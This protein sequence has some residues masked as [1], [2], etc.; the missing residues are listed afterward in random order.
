MIVIIAAAVDVRAADDAEAWKFFEAKV[1]PVLVERCLKC[2]GEAQQ[3]GQLRLDS[4]EAVLKGGESGEVVVVGKPDESLLIEAINRTGLEMPPDGPLKEHEIAA[5][6]EWVRRG[7]PWPSVEGKSRTLGVGRQISDAD[8][9]YW[10]FQPIRDPD[11]PVGSAARLS[12]PNWPRNEIDEFIAARLGTEGFVP[13]PEADRRTLLRRLT[14]DLT[15]L[16]PTPAE[17]ADFEH[18]ARDDAYER[19]VDRLLDSP[20]YGERWARHWLDLV[21]YAESDGYRK[22]DYRP[23]AWRYRDYVI[24][25]FQNDKSFDQFVQEQI[26]GDEIDPEN[27]DARTAT[28]YMRLGLYEYN[29]RDVRTQWDEILNDITDVT[30]E[31]FLGFGMGCARCHDHKFD[32]ILRKDYF[33]LRAFFAGIL[34]QDDLPLATR[35][36]IDAY[37]AK[38]AEWEAATADLRAQLADVE[39]AYRAKSRA[40]AISKFPA[41]IQGLLK[42]DDPDRLAPLDR[43]L[44]DLA[45]RQVQLEYDSVGTKLKEDAKQKW[46]ELQAEL[47][48]FDSLKPAPLPTGNTVIDVGPIAPPTIIPG[49]QSATDIPPGLLSVIDPSPAHIVPPPAAPNSSGRRTQ[50]ARWLTSPTNP[51][52]PRVMVNRIWQYHFGKGLVATSSDF[53]RLGETP[54]H[55]EL[56]DWLACRFVG[57]AESRQTAVSREAGRP[58]LGT[59]KS[60]LIPWSLKSL[61]RLIVTSAT[62]R[63]SATNPQAERQQ[64]LDP[65]NRLLWRAN[66]RR[67]DAEQIRDALLLVSGKLDMKSG[68]PSV[69]AS[70]PR[71]SIYTEQRRNS[72]YAL[73]DVFDAADGF[74][75]TPE[76]NVTTTPTQALLMINSKDALLH[77]VAFAQRVQSDAGNDREAQIR[78]AYQLA[79][80]RPATND[81]VARSLEFLNQQAAR[82]AAAASSVLTD[83]CHVLLNSNEF[84]YVD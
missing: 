61:H 33:R 32:P 55:P 28:G 78:L 20:A 6:T 12:L 62:Y 11:V 65:S 71:R 26:A 75:S 10:A 52:T 37:Q 22:D 83:F 34:P 51:L 16:P 23:N 2:H 84:L 67:L 36:E 3:K 29:Q 47:K 21:R 73:L 59:R 40:S 69:H 70:Q 46:N 15:G 1:R 27:P 63:Q 38:L 77:A 30:G 56:L 25:S 80:G 48:K 81:E 50:L 54:S 43:Q 13:A 9:A 82:N 39:K 5:L 49:D 17:I 41:D 31:V 14:F 76:R 4:R 7:L 19:V 44:H 79:Y 68:G 57:K 18:D 64:L 45:Y 42:T 53:G 58:E 72:P 66:I 24:R 74:S 8:R 35:D 60:E